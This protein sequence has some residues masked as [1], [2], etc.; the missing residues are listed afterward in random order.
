[1]LAP[2]VALFLTVFIGL[3]V[4]YIFLIFH[5]TKNKQK[6]D[7]SSLSPTFNWFNSSGSLLIAAQP[8][9][10][11]DSFNFIAGN[12]YTSENI[13]QSYKNVLK[14]Y[15]GITDYQS[16]K[17]EMTNLI[18]YGMRSSFK[19]EMEALSQKYDGYSELQ[20]IEEA[21]KL[22]K[23]ADEDSFLP[24]MLMAY[25]RMGENALLGWDI[26]RLCFITEECYLVGYIPKELMLSLC[27]KG[28]KMAQEYFKNW[29][30]MMESYLLGFQYWQRDN[31]GDPKSETAK[32]TAIYYKLHD[33]CFTFSRSPYLTVPFDTDLK[34]DE[35]TDQ[36][37]RL[38]NKC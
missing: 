28:G 24:K 31:A 16:A 34:E 29:E 21:K 6:Q 5:P 20:L 8:L 17:I 2:F 9:A 15:W 4:V 3:G 12:Q 27:V 26:G 25:R 30:E 18:D 1:M 23:N 22:D 14:D 38:I 33:G 11:G 32:R 10:N 37:G 13:D 36:Y 35:L 7:N 19:K